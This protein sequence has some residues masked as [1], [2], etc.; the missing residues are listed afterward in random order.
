MALDAVAYR[1]ML[2]QLQPPGRALPTE[3]GTVWV[4]LLDAESVELARVD[5]RADDLV[6]ESDPRTATEMLEDWERV[7][8]LPGAC[9]AVAPDTLAQRRAAVHA[10]LTARFGQRPADYEALAE[11]LGYAG[12]TVEEFRPFR[13]GQAAAGDALTNGDWV[14]AFRLRVAATTVRNFQ[15]GAG[16]AGEPLASWG[17]E[18]LECRVQERAPAHAIAI[19]AYGEEE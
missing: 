10:H 2:V 17:D 7:C 6:L 13:A 9:S 8:G 5:R 12:A 16:C 1:Q 11:S 14:H 3:E 15:A 18:L 19:F 4:A